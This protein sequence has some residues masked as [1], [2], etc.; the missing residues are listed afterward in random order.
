MNEEEIKTWLK[1][2]SEYHSRFLDLDSQIVDI[3]NS[4]TA[5]VKKAKEWKV[6]YPWMKEVSSCALQQARMDCDQAFANFFKSN[7]GTRK[8]KS[9]FPKKKRKKK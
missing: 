2:N 1:D 5:E 3:V 8:G 4:L 7:N 9:G 6:I